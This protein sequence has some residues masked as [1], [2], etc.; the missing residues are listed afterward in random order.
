MKILGFILLF[1]L[2]FVGRVD[3]ASVT[4]SISSPSQPFNEN[5]EITVHLILNIDVEDGANYY[6][7][8]A[9]RKGSGNYC[10]LTLSDGNWVE[11]GGDGNKFLKITVNEGKWE[12]DI[13]VKIDNNKSSCKESGEYKFKVK[14]YTDNSEFF[15]EQAELSM[16]F[17]L[18]TPTPTP[19]SVPT[20]TPVPTATKTPTPTSA[21]ASTSNSPTPTKKPTPS[22]SL[23]AADDETGTMEAQLMQ[24]SA[25]SQPQ[26]EVQGEGIDLGGELEDLDKKETNYNWSKLLILMGAVLVTCACGILV[27]NNYL[28]D[29]LEEM[30]TQ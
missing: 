5:T 28:K 25:A 7:G 19:T 13:K 30:R 12:G 17:N 10:G 11:Y 8:G 14:R 1:L 6:L 23:E 26:G 9:F 27:Y 4:T 2:F 15:D 24:M 29:K 21:P 18:P 20:N 3:A 16:N 22:P